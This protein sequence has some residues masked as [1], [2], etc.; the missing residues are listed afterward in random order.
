MI[1]PEIQEQI[2]DV[3][4]KLGLWNPSAGNGDRFLNHNLSKETL[5][6]LCVSDPGKLYADLVTGLERDILEHEY[7]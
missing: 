3:F 1:S 4:T 7:A 6:A 2:S 5:N